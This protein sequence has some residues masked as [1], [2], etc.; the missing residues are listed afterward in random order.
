M[1][2]KV[3]DKQYD[4]LHPSNSWASCLGM[5]WMATENRGFFASFVSCI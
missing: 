2:F 1:T 4:R 5:A 3:S